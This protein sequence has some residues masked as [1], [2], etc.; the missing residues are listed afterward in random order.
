MTADESSTGRRLLIVFIIFLGLG[1]LAAGIVYWVQAR[2]FP[3]VV[4]I[5]PPDRPPAKPDP[6]G[7]RGTLIPVSPDLLHVTSIAL[8]NPRLTIVNGKR[9]AEEDWLVVKTPN[10]EASVRV[11]SIQDG[12]VKFKHGGETINA[13]LQLV[14]Q[15]PSPH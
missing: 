6:L 13:P 10:G 11:I 2:Q 4:A 12:L 14:Q 5:S 8:G 3:V 1:I 9:L 7:N 15:S